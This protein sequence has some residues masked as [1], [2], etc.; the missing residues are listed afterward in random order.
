MNGGNMNKIFPWM[1]RSS[2]SLLLTFLVAASLLLS[3]CGGSDSYK[4]PTLVS[5][6][7]LPGHATN[8]LIEAE[9]LKEWMDA[10][11]VNAADSFN[12][13]VVILDYYSPDSALRIPGAGKVATGELAAIRLEGI[14]ETGSMVPTGAMIDAVIQRLGI[15]ENTTIVFT[16]DSFFYATRAH[17]VF[18]YWG[19]PRERLK[20]LN[21]GNGAWTAAVNAG[22]WG[23]DYALTSDVPSPIPSTYSVRKNG[24]LR[25][26]LRFSIGEMITEVLPALDAGTMLHLD[27]LGPAHAAGT[28]TNLT[29]DL[30]D[31][32][33]W[34]VFEGRIEGSKPLG[35]GTLH[36]ANVGFKDVDTLRQLFE[37]AGWEPGL[38][39]SVACRA[40][41]TCTIIFFALEEILG[42]PAY[43]YDGSWGQWGLY[44][45]NTA[46]GGKIP[47]TLDPLRAQWATD[48]Y[49]VSGPMAA[50]VDAPVY[51]V[52]SPKVVNGAP[53][54]LT[55]DDIAVLRLNT[56]ALYGTNGPSDPRANQIEN[57]D[58]EY[59]ATPPAAGGAPGPVTGGGGGC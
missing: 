46:E 39:T 50:P 40:G 9:T 5:S 17:F 13:R 24:V 3:G 27:A 45:N 56:G 23:P 37:A 43:V 41:V 15:D 30:I 7:A 26:D 54:V 19:F 58:R 49:T 25:D 2:F 4:E 20:V 53:R 51:N 59:M 44:S 34:V 28:A 57:E 32:S 47:A 22:E 35:Q 14:A 18:R 33:K 21:G 12:G 8:S 16:S 52:G 42:S 38:R 1:R 31:T 55:L 36:D 48:Q 10:G 11:L 6:A 29:T